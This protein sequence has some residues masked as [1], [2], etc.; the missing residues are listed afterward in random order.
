VRYSDNTSDSTLV[1][2]SSDNTV[3]SV[4]STSGKIIGLKSGEAT[5]MATAARDNSKRASLQIS[6]RPGGTATYA[7]SL[8]PNTLQLKAGA[9]GTLKAA[10]QLLEGGESRESSNVNWSSSN[11]AVA[12]VQGN[13]SSAV[14][15]AVGPGK[16]TITVSADQDPTKSA[17]AEVTVE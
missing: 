6:V 15:A 8:S 10:A 16:A 4:D 17:S 13:G 12:I 7:I 5:L 11:R 14:V 2:S 1:W 3:V 9:T